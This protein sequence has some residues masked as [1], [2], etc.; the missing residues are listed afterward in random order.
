[1]LARYA[2][3]SIETDRPDAIEDALALRLAA[4]DAPEVVLRV[5]HQLHG[6][7]GFGDE[8]TLSWISRY[9]Q[10]LRRLPL[11]LSAPP[12]LPADSPD[13]PRLPGLFRHPPGRCP[14]PPAP[15]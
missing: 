10:P 12:H 9:S 2:L 11:V 6:A 8:T 3:W 4:I 13:R 14:P 5:T 1:M 7:T 15:H